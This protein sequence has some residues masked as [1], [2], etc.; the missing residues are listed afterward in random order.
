LDGD[1]V[2]EKP[3]ELDDYE[4]ELDDER[5]CQLGGSS[6]AAKSKD[7]AKTVDQLMDWQHFGHPFSPGIFQVWI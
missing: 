5:D 4:F 2:N 1:L 7:A 6:L 3:P